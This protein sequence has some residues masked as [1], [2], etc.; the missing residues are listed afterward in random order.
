MVEN[1]SQIEVTETNKKEF[2][3]AMAYAKMAKEIDEILK[4]IVFDNGILRIDWQKDQN[5][6]SEILRSI[7]DY[8]FEAKIR[9]GIDFTFEKIDQMVEEVLKMAKT[10]FV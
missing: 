5:I 1:G 2:V 7:D 3:K 6:E 4:N 8:F 9:F 10:K